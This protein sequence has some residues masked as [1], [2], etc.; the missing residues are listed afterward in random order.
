MPSG[1]AEGLVPYVTWHLEHPES[2][3]GNKSKEY[4]W[5]TLEIRVSDLASLPF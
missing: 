3:L 5:L 4:S 1:S 2:P